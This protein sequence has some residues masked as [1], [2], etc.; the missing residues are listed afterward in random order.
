MVLFPTS[1]VVSVAAF[2][3]EL[4]CIHKIVQFAARYVGCYVKH[5]GTASAWDARCATQMYAA[6]AERTL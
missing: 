6:A 4:D 5:P 3:C 1:G 2:A